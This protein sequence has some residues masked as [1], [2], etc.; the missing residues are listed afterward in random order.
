MS[1]YFSS[2]LHSIKCVQDTLDLLDS[3][4]VLQSREGMRSEKEEFYDV[5]FQWKC[6]DVGIGIYVAYHKQTNEIQLM[7]I[8]LRALQ[9]KVPRRIGKIVRPDGTCIQLVEPRLE[10]VRY[11]RKLLCKAIEDGNVINLGEL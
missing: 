3:S 11:V 10:V 1:I 2:E 4:L 6:Y 8:E 9:R 7:D 5:H